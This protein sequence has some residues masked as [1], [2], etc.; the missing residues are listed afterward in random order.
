MPPE[1]GRKWGT[2]CLNIRFPL[3]TLQCAGYSV[4]LIYFIYLFILIEA[5][6]WRRG[7]EAQTC[8]YNAADVGSIPIRGNEL[9]FINIFI[10]YQNHAW[11]TIYMKIKQKY[12]R[13]R[14]HVRP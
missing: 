3:P 12:I 6:A 9:L 14:P 13:A 2:E 8:D 1:F 11:D 7:A 4:K 10:L 5:A